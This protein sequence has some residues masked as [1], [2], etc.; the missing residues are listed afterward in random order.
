MKNYLKHFLFAFLCTLVFTGCINYKRL[1][2]DEVVL[3]DG[4]SQT[5]TILKTDSS[6]IK[7]EKIDES[8]SII[9]W[10]TI[11][12]IQGKKL[13][14]IWGG[15]NIGYYNIPYFSV[16]RNEPFTGNALGVQYKVGMAFRGNKLVYTHLSY[17][18]A[19]PYSITK[20]G[21]G[22]QKYLGHSTYLK[23]NAFFWGS[24][25][26]F[27]NV[28]FNNGTQTT[29]EPYTG[30]ER[31]LNERIRLHFKFGLQFNLANKNNQTGVNFTIGAHFLKK[32]FKKEYE[33]L[34]KEHKF[35]RK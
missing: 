7:L 22:Y 32:D 16:F 30:F 11:D 6:T 26:N 8:I 18:P 31:K 4:N 33:T 12:T 20:F 27:M 1:L 25:F 2:T 21:V 23:K 34:N 15:M 24:E 3:K 17:S 13:K 9:P 5:G 28:K 10:S 14:T 19:K 29:L 35:Y